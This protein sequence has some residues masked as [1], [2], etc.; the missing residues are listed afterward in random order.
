MSKASGGPLGEMKIFEQLTSSS[1]EPC[2]TYRMA[3][4]GGWVYYLRESYRE[5]CAV[6][7]PDPKA[8]V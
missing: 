3:V 1:G 4:P 8:Y 6:Y 7:V 2:Q 5:P